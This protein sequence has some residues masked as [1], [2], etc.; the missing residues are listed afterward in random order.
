MVM[1]GEEDG[2][3]DTMTQLGGKPNNEDKSNN[4]KK[5]IQRHAHQSMT[6]M[7]VVNSCKK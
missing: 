2:V 6:L 3:V 4:I 5:D 1:I 7:I